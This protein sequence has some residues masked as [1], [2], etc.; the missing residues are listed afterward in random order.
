LNPT[1]L[2]DEL[3]ELPELVEEDPRIAERR[4]AVQLE[5]RHRRRRWFLAVLIVFTVMAG[6]WLVTRTALFDVDEIKV[7]GVAHATPEQVVEASGLH[8]GDQLLDI[9]PSAV[10]SRV[11]T[12]P[13]VD[14]VEV[15]RRMGGVVTIVVSERTA[16]ATVAD[17]M[18]GLHLVDGSG[19]VLGPVEGDTGTLHFLEGLNAG[20]PGEPIPGADAALHALATLTP[21]V[22][23]RVSAIVVA[24]DGSLSLRLRPEGVARLGPPTD[25]ANKVAKL[26]T[27]MGQVDQRNIAGIDVSNPDSP[28]LWRN[29]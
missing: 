15:E 18:G 19:R 26:V 9:Q 3:A 21:G 10:A 23:L 6:A 16:V 7:Q 8:L 25:L 13:W 14:G 11:A 17:A 12:L 28:T 4:L 1:L 24:D 20:P 27:L 2:E 29:P 5:R 22:R